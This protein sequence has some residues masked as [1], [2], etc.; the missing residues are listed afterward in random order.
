[1]SSLYE[2][3]GGEADVDAAVDGF[4]DKVLADVRIRHFFAN[5][6][7][8]RQRAHQRA[9]LTYAFGGASGYAGRGMRAAHV[10]LGLTDSHFDAVV[11]NL[12][13][14]LRDLGVTEPLITEVVATAETLRANVLCR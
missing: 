14:A 4:Y 6:D 10:G 5:T 2:R 13:A 11:E 8:K 3:L 1:M 7:M 9:F 12:A